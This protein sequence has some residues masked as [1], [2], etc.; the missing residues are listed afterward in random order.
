MSPKLLGLLVG[1]LVPA[2]FFGVSG[3]FSKTSGDAGMPV[4]PHLMFIGLG[5]SATGVLF[6][7]ALPGGVP[8]SGAIAS[9]SLLG[10]FWSLGIGF[11]FIALVRY[12]TPL[13]QLVPLYNM[14]TL[15]TVA[16]ALVVFAEWKDTNVAQLLLGAGLIVAGGVL[17]SGA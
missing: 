17:V 14:N 11:L 16:I 9:S 8:S 12:Q 15:I 2:L 5:V 6:N 10:F 1:G 4:G 13:S 7:L 3:V